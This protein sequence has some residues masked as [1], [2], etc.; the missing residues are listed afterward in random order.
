MTSVEK[1]YAKKIFLTG[2]KSLRINSFLK[3]T[4][5]SPLKKHT[6]EQSRLKYIKENYNF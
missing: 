6:A 5:L 2:R 4:Y 1:L 3:V